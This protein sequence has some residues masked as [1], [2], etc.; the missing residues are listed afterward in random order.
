MARQERTQEGSVL[1]R[2]SLEHWNKWRN[3]FA[4][5]SLRC[6]RGSETGGNASG[7]LP[8]T[9][10]FSGSVPTSGLT[11]DTVDFFIRPAL[12]P[13]NSETSFN[14]RNDC[15]ETPSFAAGLSALLSSAGPFGVLG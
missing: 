2:K 6:S 14:G 1:H 10:D 12:V 9:P 4:C 3:P 5:M 11:G 15:V 7:T 13:L 8:R